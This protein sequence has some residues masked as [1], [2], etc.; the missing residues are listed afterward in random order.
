M[1]NIVN[2]KLSRAKQDSTP[3][4]GP[5]RSA[6]SG[7]EISGAKLRSYV[8]AYFEHVHPLYPFLDR[9][10]FEA[11]VMDVQTRD[12]SS[13]FRALYHSVLAL[14]CQYVVADCSFTPGKGEAWSYFN[15]ALSLLPDVLLPPGALVNLQVCLC[16]Q[17]L[18][19]VT[20]LTPHPPEGNHC[21]GRSSSYMK[22]VLK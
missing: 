13:A 5:A 9:P 4:F 11:S 21:Y 1:S 17:T 2:A 7:I 6:S 12:K 8:E 3:L 20:H 16:I 22:H 18:T 14:G 15:V 10:K 19:E